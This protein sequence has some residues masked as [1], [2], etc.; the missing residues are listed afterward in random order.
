MEVVKAS[1]SKGK[2]IR[3]GNKKRKPGRRG[4]LSYNLF[5]K[6]NN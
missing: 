3:R 1:E 6:G 5:I 4:S 2:K